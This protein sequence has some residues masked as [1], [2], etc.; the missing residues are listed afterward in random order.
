MPAVHANDVL[1][2][3]QRLEILS[4]AEVE[5]ARGWS[6]DSAE[7]TSTLLYAGLTHFQ[8]QAVRQGR[9]ERLI[10]GPYLLLDLIAEGGMGTVYQARHI[11]LGRVVALKIIRSDKLKSK[12][13]S[14]RFLREI[15]MTASFEHPYIIRA[16]D[17]GVIADNIYL[18]TEFITG[19]DLA[20]HVRKHGPMKAAE[21]W[22]V[23]RQ[24]ALALQHIHERDL[25]HRDVKPSNLIRDNATGDIKL[26][27]LGLCS[28][29]HEGACFDSDAGSIT[30]NG[31]LLGTPDYLSPEQARDPHNVDIR[32]DLYSLG[33]TFYFLL[34]G[35]PLFP[36]GSAVDKLMKHLY[37]PPPVPVSPYGEL[38][39]AMREAIIKLLA[40]K[41]EDRFPTPLAML[42]QLP[43]GGGGPAGND[44]ENPFVFTSPGPLEL[45]ETDPGETIEITIQN[46]REWLWLIGAMS[47]LL[48]STAL[49]ASAYLKR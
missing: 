12:V 21:A 15:R 13:V 33:A 41:P 23:I 48:L 47:T 45:S 25:V 5:R 22:K 43:D 4:A 8:I 38:P 46:S 3:L 11:R 44:E 7:L 31:V 26:L 39:R 2:D 20:S 29:P 40:K 42:Q 49:I 16:Y 24:T 30:R 37:E 34:T 6:T 27:D 10:V 18:A 36:S 14:K 17:A 35:K 9:L 32:A 28:L 19:S 1:A